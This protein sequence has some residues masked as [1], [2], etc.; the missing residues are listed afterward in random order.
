ME[1]EMNFEKIRDRLIKLKNL[2]ERGCQGE[3][4]AARNAL[5]RLLKKYNLTVDDL[6]SEEKT[7]RWIKTGRQGY[8]R[9]LLFQ[10]YYSVFDATEVMR[11]QYRDEI[12]FELTAYEYAELA[13]AYEWHVANFEK[14]LKRMKED[15]LSAYIYRHDLCS[16]TGVDDSKNT[17]SRMSME[18]ISRILNLAGNLSNEIYCKA[19]N[20]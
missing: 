18:D 15:L 10:C 16:Q 5:E 19:L 9:K 17:D 7:W 2:A 3:A 20:S 4:I 1:S 11:K 6:D 12:A 8:S 14:E 13:N